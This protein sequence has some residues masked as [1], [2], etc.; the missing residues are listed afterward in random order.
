M[1]Y[2]DKRVS[3][4]SNMI[5]CMKSIKSFGWESIFLEKIKKFRGG[6]FFNITMWRSMDGI[7]GIIWKSLR[8]VL[9]FVFLTS[10]LS[11]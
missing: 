6:E 8:I 4:M 10:F 9:Q 5:E 11:K 1:T 3:L 7:L 2:K